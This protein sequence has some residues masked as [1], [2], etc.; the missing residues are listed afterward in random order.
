MKLIKKS[1]AVLLTLAML[2]SLT[3]AASAMG[4]AEGTCGL[5][6]TWELSFAGGLTI[7]GNGDIK[8]YA[9]KSSVDFR[10]YSAQ[11][12]SVVMK[13]GITGVGAYA[14]QSMTALTSVK[15]TDNVL[16]IDRY[17]FADCPVLSDITLPSTLLFIGANAFSNC[18]SL[19]S[20]VIPAGITNLYAKTFAG[21]TALKTVEIRNKNC[22]FATNDIL[23][24]GVTDGA[25]LRAEERSGVP[26]VERNGYGTDNPAGNAADFGY[27]DDNGRRQVSA[28]R[29]D[30][31]GLPGQ[32]DRRRPQ[33][34]LLAADALWYEII[35]GTTITCGCIGLILFTIS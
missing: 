7:A 10:K 32:P 12:K 11:I 21:C 6:A 4:L 14:F 20:A 22:V 3:G 19:K 15:M 34:H 8:A 28:L 27:S 17:A 23:P 2:L 29:S 25:V 26:S 30:A 1:F 5:H 24:Q 16:T 35:R 18:T 33:L 9:P 13:D 31:R